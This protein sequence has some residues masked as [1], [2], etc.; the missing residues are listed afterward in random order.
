VDGPFLYWWDIPHAL[1][2]SLEHYE[3]IRF[4]LKD[5]GASCL[6]PVSR[7]KPLLTSE[8]QSN[9]KARSWGIKVLKNR[10]NELAIEPVKQKGGDWAYL[11]VD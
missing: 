7:L 5:T 3:A 11:P 6:V 2:E 8:R 1:A 9:R 10:E 4:V